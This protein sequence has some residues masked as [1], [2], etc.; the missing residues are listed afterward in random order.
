MA[1]QFNYQGDTTLGM[2]SN[3]R[4]VP[5]NGSNGSSIRL[6]PSI[7]DRLKPDPSTQVAGMPPGYGQ[8]PFPQVMTMQGLVSTIS[9]CYRTDDEALKNSLENARFMEFDVGIQECVEG[10]TRSVALLNW[11]LEPDD[12]SS[13]DQREFCEHFSKMLRGIPRF[14]QFRENLARAIWYGRSANKVRNQWQQYGSQRQAFISDWLPVHGDKLVF[15]LDNGMFDF[16]PKQV[17]VRVG[18]TE[19]EKIGGY[20]DIEVTDRGR[21]YF[22]T[23]AERKLLVLHKHQM[24]DAA[25]EDVQSAGRIHGTGLRSD[26]YWEWFQKQETLR[27]MMEYLERSAFGVDLWFYPDGNMAAMQS[28]QT[29]AKERISNYRNQIF[30]PVPADGLNNQYGLQHVET[31]MAGMQA[32]Q[33]LV[34]RYFGHRIK[35]RIL[36][37]TLTSESEGGGL[38][39]DGI[40]RVHLGTFKDIVRYDAVNL[41]ET[42]TTDVI[43]PGKEF[44]FRHAK[45]GVRF[46]IETEEIDGDQRIEQISR[47]F[48]MGARISEKKLLD[49]VGLAVPGDDDRTLV[50][51]QFA[52]QGQGPQP[53]QPGH[54]A[55]D[56]GPH[57]DIAADMRK[58]LRDR[59]ALTP[60]PADLGSPGVGSG[61]DSFSS[62]KGMAG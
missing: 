18:Y 35:R 11:H 62:S 56:G 14:M 19:G 51:P 3:N 26:I 37:Q 38:G 59:N 48:Q 28:M 12:P 49:A 16:D 10:R 44:N 17:G 15:R 46:R 1:N 5:V 61:F 53:G 27:W 34:E 36:G 40:A 7:L 23:P 31:G 25:Y 2:I 32:I 30:V 50:N 22:L 55:Q 52:Q 42:I 57:D 8:Y 6:A 60:P 13:Q 45:F 54:I 20:H 39:S 41:E 58:A 33:E 47:I 9:K 4:D 29:A 24:R 43:I 21:A